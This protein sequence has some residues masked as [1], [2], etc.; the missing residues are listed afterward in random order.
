[1]RTAW[2]LEW[3]SDV[4]GS[5]D[6]EAGACERLSGREGWDLIW[7]SRKNVSCYECRANQ[8]VYCCRRDSKFGLDLALALSLRFALAVHGY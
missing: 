4:V 3:K 1:M 2:T 6:V 8:P 5:Y 7:E